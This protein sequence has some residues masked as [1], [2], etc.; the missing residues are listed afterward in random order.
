MEFKAS[1]MQ[2]KDSLMQFKAS[3]MQFKDSLTEFKASLMQFK[4]SLT[5]FKASYAIPPAPAPCPMPHALIPK[6]YVSSRS[7][8]ALSH[9]VAA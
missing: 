5:E 2:F 4:D 7:E 9:L 3:L 6:N 1:L 8:S